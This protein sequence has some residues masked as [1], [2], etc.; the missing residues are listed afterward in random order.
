M[1]LSIRNLGTYLAVQSMDWAKSRQI[2]SRPHQNSYHVIRLVYKLKNIHL[3]K[4]F[5]LC[6]LKGLAVWANIEDWRIIPAS[7]LE[8]ELDIIIPTYVTI[9]SQ[10]LI[11]AGLAH[12]AGRVLLKPFIQTLH[13][14]MMPAF[15]LQVYL[16][17][18]TNRA[19]LCLIN[20]SS[21]LINIPIFFLHI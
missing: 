6:M 16:I 1:V 3:S 8:I 20:F 18:K 19:D 15:S 12:G 11:A 21:F 17:M 7:F 14:E 9:F 5:M 4:K 10:L 2:F 13:M